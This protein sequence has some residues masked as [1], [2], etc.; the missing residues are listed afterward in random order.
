MSEV[1]RPAAGD[2]RD[3][4]ARARAPDPRPSR[5]GD[6]GAAPRPGARPDRRCGGRRAV[7]PTRAP[8][9]VNDEP[10]ERRADAAPRG[11]RALWMCSIGTALSVAT[12]APDG[13]YVTG[14]VSASLRR[15]MRF[16]AATRDPRRSLR[17]ATLRAGG[18]I[19]SGE[20]HYTIPSAP[21]DPDDLAIPAGRA[22]LHVAG[23]FLDVFTALH[24]L[25][26]ICSA[27]ARQLD[28]SAAPPEPKGTP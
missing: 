18:A 27:V 16:G 25:E 6:R 10:R 9:R 28:A 7:G 22:H 17:L 15:P 12:N 13:L 3:H 19:V 2:G 23:A 1:P 21:P 24:R 20:P 26:A 4:R 11:R 14:A 5:T 8:A